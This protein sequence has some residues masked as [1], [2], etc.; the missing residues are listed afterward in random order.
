[1]ACFLVPMAEAIIVSMAKNIVERKERKALS[2]ELT[3]KE[4]RNSSHIKTKNNIQM[5]L[6]WSQKLSWLSNLL[7]G[8][9]FLLAIE[10]LWHGEIILCPPFL[11]AM[12]NPNDIL[13]MLHEMALVG[14]S[15][16]VFL[17][18]VWGVMIFVTE[19][20]MKHF[21]IETED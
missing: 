16:A 15:M 18:I 21:K 2:V 8:G 4:L 17:T 19:H 11:T 14:T 7:W 5:G 9:V 20:R 10:H 3:S 1:M 12:R 13:P 6:N